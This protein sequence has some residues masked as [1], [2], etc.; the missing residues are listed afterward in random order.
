MLK[1]LVPF[2][3]TIREVLEHRGEAEDWELLGNIAAILMD[4]EEHRGLDS[5]TD[6][7]RYLA[8]IDAMTR[9]VNNGGWEQFFT[10]SSGAF[11][12]DLVP[13]LESVGSSDF[14]AIAREAVGLFGQIA[15]LDEDTRY[16]QV[17]RL[18]EDGDLQPWESCDEAVFACTEKVET[19]AID[20]AIARRQD[21]VD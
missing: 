15:S 14:Q 20:Y 12:Y 18:T 1:E 5:L 7:E 2:G 8:A 16:D 6:S 21:F 17:E 11:A 13:A 19:L 9:Q 10:N 3:T 4:K